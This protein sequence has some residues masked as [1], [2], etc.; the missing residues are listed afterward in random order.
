MRCFV[1][2]ENDPRNYKTYTKTYEQL[3]DGKLN[4]PIKD[5]IWRVVP[6]TVDMAKPLAALAAVVA[7]IVIAVKFL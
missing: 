3:C 1:L 6:T 2:D 4:T 7:L 5:A